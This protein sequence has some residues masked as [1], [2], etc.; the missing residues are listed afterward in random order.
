MGHVSVLQNLWML[1]SAMLTCT[2]THD[3]CLSCRITTSTTARRAKSPNG[4]RTRTAPVRLYLPHQHPLL[5]AC[6]VSMTAVCSP[7]RFCQ[8]QPESFLWLFSVPRE[9]E[10]QKIQILQQGEGGVCET[11][12]NFWRKEG[13]LILCQEKS[14]AACLLL[15]RIRIRTFRIS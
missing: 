1:S 9:R 11:R 4:E 12:E 10:E 15:R 6:G 2:L 8:K 13:Q 3:C 5:K 14:S 7:S